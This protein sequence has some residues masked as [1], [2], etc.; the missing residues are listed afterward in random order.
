[1]SYQSQ[2]ETAAD[3]RFRARVL[4]CATEQA[5]IFVNDDRPEFNRFARAVIAGQGSAH[6]LVPMVASQ[7]GISPDSSDPELLAAVQAMWPVHGA[8]YVPSNPTT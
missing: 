6:G 3:P 7:P 4:A 5:V 1:M 8:T 2:A